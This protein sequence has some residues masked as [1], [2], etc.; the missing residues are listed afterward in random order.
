MEALRSQLLTLAYQKLNLAAIHEW[1]K[2]PNNHFQ[3]DPGL[4][5]GRRP[6]C[7]RV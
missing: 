1:G 6:S 7:G 4:R 3:F 2:W 5:E